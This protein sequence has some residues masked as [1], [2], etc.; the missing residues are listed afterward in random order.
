MSRDAVLLPFEGRTPR[1]HPDAWIAPGA[2]LIGD[3]VVAAGASVWYGCVLRADGDTV[4]ISE[5]ANVQDLT[6]VHA[7]PGRPVTVGPRTSVGHRVL[8]HG[9]TVGADCIV[10]MSATLL[11]HCDIG[12]GSLVAAGAVVREGMTVPPGSLVVGVPAQVKR[13]VSDAEAARIR[14]NGTIYAGLTQRHRA[15]VDAGWPTA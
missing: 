5:G 3:V 10:G 14:R 6:V 12:D 1:V 15:A 4:T 8:L 2:V 7:D 9:C 11:N 13:P